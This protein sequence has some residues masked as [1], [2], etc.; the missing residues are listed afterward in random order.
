ME[1]TWRKHGGNREETGSF[2]G[3]GS[4]EYGPNRERMEPGYHRLNY[5]SHN[6]SYLGMFFTK[7]ASF[8][9]H[10]LKNNTDLGMFSGM[11]TSPNSDANFSSSLDILSISRHGTGGLIAV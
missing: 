10:I 11:M 7:T 8:N 4:Q 2:K 3:G 9:I 5:P 1:E 6:N